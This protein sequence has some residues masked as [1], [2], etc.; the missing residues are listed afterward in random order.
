MTATDLNG[1]VRI[2][3]SL[4]WFPETSRPVGVLIVSKNLDARLLLANHLEN[5]GYGVWTAGSGTDAFQIGIAHPVAIDM[6]VCDEA[7]S[8]IPVPELYSSLNAR[9][10][11]L[12]CCVLVTTKTQT[13]ANDA[14]KLNAVPSTLAGQTES[15]ECPTHLNSISKDDPL[16]G[17]LTAGEIHQLEHSGLSL[18]DAI[19]AIE[20]SEG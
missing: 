17:V 5:L 14:E 6:L 7:I 1:V 16:V 10:P 9:I 11:G 2:L 12:R 4:E 18:E 8:D 19:R 15:L 13:H 3:A 20:S